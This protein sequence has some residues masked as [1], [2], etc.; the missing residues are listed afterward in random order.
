MRLILRY[1]KNV[2]VCNINGVNFDCGNGVVTID[3]G[4]IKLFINSNGL[5]GEGKLIE[6]SDLSDALLTIKEGT[7]TV[8]IDDFNYENAV[9][10][11]YDIL[12]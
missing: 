3:C 12:F 11:L 4:D 7:K 5:F 8:F 6:D 10:E 2:L 9:V 1:S